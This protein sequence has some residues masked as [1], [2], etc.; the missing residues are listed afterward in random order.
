[1]A[2][3]GSLSNRA[4]ERVEDWNDK[5]RGYESHK[6][7]GANNGYANLPSNEKAYQGRTRGHLAAGGS[8]TVSGGGYKKTYGA[9]S[10]PRIPSNESDY[11]NRTRGGR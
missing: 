1:M 11:Q 2:G 9:D 3:L 8:E 5:H 6:T 4:W 7:Y 10:A